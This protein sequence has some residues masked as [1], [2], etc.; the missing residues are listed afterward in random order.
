MTDPA[1]LF[2]EGVHHIPYSVSFSLMKG[3]GMCRERT[4]MRKIREILTHRFTHGL[5]FEKTALAVRKSK[6][7]IYSTCTQF[8]ASGLPWPLPT[9]MTDEQLERAIF[10][11]KCL[12]QVS[13][14]TLPDITYIE[15]ELAKK[16]VTVQLLYR[17]YKDQQ[18]DGMSQASFYRYIKSKKSPKLSMHL[19][20]KGGD[21]LYCDYSGDGLSYVDRSTGEIH[22]VE[23]F[24]ASLAASSYTYAEAS[25]SQQDQHF[26]MSHVRAYE[27]FGG[28][29]ACIVPDNLKSAITKANRYDPTI[30]LVFA[31]FAEH[32]GTVV[33]PARVATPRD[34][35][36]VES[37][38]LTTQRWIIAALRNQIFF[39]LSEINL[40]IMQKLELVNDRPMRDHGGLSRL[41]RFMEQDKPY[42]K[43]L[44]Q[45]PFRISAVKHDVSVGVNYH[46]QFKKHFYSAPFALARK[47]VDVHLN[48]STIEIYHNGQ[49]CCRHQFSARHGG[50]TTNSEHMP[51]NHAFVHGMRPEWYVAKAGEISPSTATMAEAIMK[52]C[53][54]PQQGFRAVQGLLRLAKVYPHDRMEAACARALHLKAHRF[55]DVKSILEQGLD[56]QQ[57]I[58]FPSSEPDVH[59]NIRGAQYYENT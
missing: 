22:K 43:A 1:G 6:G 30:N 42:L 13:T 54:H 53:A 14:A 18:P 24:V 25:H 21:I 47:K 59:G 37:A 32:Y 46:I 10:Q 55:V 28:S 33:L 8:T 51:P 38:V 45:S 11:D 2:S 44:P 56:A 48:G 39:S 50:Y 31:K 20:H 34:K 12:L 52:K 57:V 40:A 9:D 26:T 7:C 49:H 58:L 35:G 36:G 17:E 23:L 4:P 27:F 41:Q 16:H 29:T 5:S 3:S 15:Q 19:L